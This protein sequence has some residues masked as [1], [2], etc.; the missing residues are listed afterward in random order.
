MTLP[1][2][3]PTVK[4][5]KIGVILMNLG[6]PDAPDAP[7]L[8]R[9]LA[10]FL[11]DQR[12]IDYPA[13]LWQPLL[14]GIILNTRPRKSAALYAK[15]W[16]YERG[17]SPLRLILGD[18]VEAMQARIDPEAEH[19]IFRAG[20]RYGSP[21][22]TDVLQE[23][24]DLGCQQIVMAAI[25]PHYAGATT[26][27]GYDEGFAFLQKANWQPAVR[28]MPAYCDHPAYIHALAQSVER[29][30]ETLDWTPDVIITSY[31]GVPQR[32]LTG[33]GDPY[34]CQCYKTTRLLGEALPAIAD[35]LK[36]TFQSRFGPEKWLQPYTD[37]TIDALGAEG[38]KIAVLTPGFSADCLETLDEIGNEAHEDF[39]E[40]GGTHFAY[41]PC[42]NT[43]PAHL[44]MLES[45]IRRELSGWFPLHEGAEMR[46]SE[47]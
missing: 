39:T 37:E 26:A 40:A 33:K 42:L 7:S 5:P 8:K 31:H 4:A 11:S 45:L 41:I 17:D 13:W 21:S 19:V 10:Q 15:I 29:H 18:Q 23:L 22:T 6:T 43:E 1:A 44:D 25:Y 35:K 9:Y 30:L 46:I 14:R 28:T 32:Y 24:Q 20:M 36:V 27:T 38:K 2:D 16:D 47:G 3:H 34:H 12:V